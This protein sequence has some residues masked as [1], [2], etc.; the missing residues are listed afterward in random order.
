M[1]GASASVDAKMEAVQ[2]GHGLHWKGV[3]DGPWTVQ[4]AL[5]HSRT[6]PHLSCV[7]EMLLALHAVEGSL[8]RARQ[9]MVEALVLHLL[10]VDL[11]PYSK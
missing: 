1:A 10:W 5:K 9:P 8:P 3:G 4:E 7:K 2:K 6:K 11:Q